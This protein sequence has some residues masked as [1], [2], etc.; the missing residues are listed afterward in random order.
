MSLWSNNGKQLAELGG[1]QGSV[2]S[3][4]IST[5]GR[6]I[7][8]GG[9]DGIVRLWDIQFKSWLKAACERLQYHPVF[10]NPKTYDQRE[11]KAA[12]E[13]YLH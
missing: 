13:P 7:V 10:K 12:C 6:T 9:Q 4:A 8:S 1:H 11:A 3:V 5:D 2:Y